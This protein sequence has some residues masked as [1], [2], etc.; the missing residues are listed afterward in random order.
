MKILSMT[1]EAKYEKTCKS[2]CG[3]AYTIGLSRSYKDC[4]TNKRLSDYQMIYIHELNT[5]PMCII[6]S[7]TSLYNKLMHQKSKMRQSRTHRS[8]STARRYTHAMI[9]AELDDIDTSPPSDGHA[10]LRGIEGHVAHTRLRRD[11]PRGAPD[12]GPQPRQ[13]FH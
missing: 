9:T 1:D 5:A 4:D 7:N 12:E 3:K 6:R 11:L 2:I 13:Q 8:S 10:C